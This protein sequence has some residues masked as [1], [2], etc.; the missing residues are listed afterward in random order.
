MANERTGIPF[1]RDVM[2]NYGWMSSVML[3]HYLLRCTTLSAQ[4]SLNVNG[5]W[6]SNC[7]AEYDAAVAEIWSKAVSGLQ[8]P[9][10]LRKYPSVLERLTNELTK[11][12]KSTSHRELQSKLLQHARL[13]LMQVMEKIVEEHGALRSSTTYG[14]LE[15]SQ[16][17][18]PVIELD[19]VHV[20]GINAGPLLSGNL[21]VQEAQCAPATRPKTNEGQ[22]RHKQQ[23]EVFIAIKNIDDIPSGKGTMPDIFATRTRPTTSTEREPATMG[24]PATPDLKAPQVKTPASASIP[25]TPETVV[26]VMALLDTGATGSFV[27]ADVLKA[28]AKALDKGADIDFSTVSGIDAQSEP[29]R[30]WPNWVARLRELATDELHTGLEFVGSSSICIAASRLYAAAMKPKP[31]CLLALLVVRSKLFTS[32]RCVFGVTTGPGS[33]GHTLG[34]LIA[35]FRTLCAATLLCFLLLCFV[36]DI[37]CAGLD[38]ARAVCWL[39]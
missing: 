34:E 7:H 9:G 8:R 30:N 32:D 20:N 26:L 13:N 1:R 5:E 29:M 12:W 23:G 6:S 31:P 38:G 14:S 18:P 33:L 4:Q 17:P 15:A 11:T 39:I 27:R 24:K 3:Y 35:V 19:E 37:L 10:N 28:L 16:L 22:T 2:K 25:Q 36:D 21:D